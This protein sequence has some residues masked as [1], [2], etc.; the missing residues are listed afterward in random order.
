MRSTWLSVFLLTVLCVPAF[1]ADPPKGFRAIFNGTDLKGWY[2]LNPHGTEKLTGEKKEANL[3][4][5][6]EDFANHWRVE[7]ASWSTMA[8]A[9]MPRPTKSSAIWSC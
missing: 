8:P 7:T 4:K 9:P 6:R 1:A 2:G 5:Q 3:K